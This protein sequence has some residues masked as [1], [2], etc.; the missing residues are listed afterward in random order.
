MSL[1]LVKG[2]PAR[3]KILRVT[4]F[5]RDLKIL[6][7]SWQKKKVLKLYAFGFSLNN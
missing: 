4:R 5:A 1:T 2:L 7:K 6:A 3:Q